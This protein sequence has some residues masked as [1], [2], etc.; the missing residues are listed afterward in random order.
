LPDSSV[1]CSAAHYDG[2]VKNIR[3]GKGN[4]DMLKLRLAVGILSVSSLVVLVGL[5]A[6]Q[7][8]MAA[9]PHAVP[10]HAIHAKADAATP[11]SGCGAC[12]PGS[13]YT[14][15]LLDNSNLDCLNG[16]LALV[17]LTTCNNNDAHMSWTEDEYSVY[18]DVAY[19]LI[20]DE[21]NECL[22]GTLAKVYLTPCNAADLHMEWLVLQTNVGL[23]NDMFE[24]AEDPGYCLNG[25]LVTSHAEITLT[26]CNVND[27]HMLWYDGGFPL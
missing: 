20:N 11:D 6:P 12:L 21:N 14:S 2:N 1:K 26:K 7:S 18:G 9:T 10:V 4:N 5:T 24:S 25:A 15:E 23:Q 19:A 3:E 22:N 27:D 17:Y 16:T 13:G 8:A